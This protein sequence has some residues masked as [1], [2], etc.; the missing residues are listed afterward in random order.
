MFEQFQK[1]AN[2]YFL[3]IAILQS[4]PQISVTGGIPNILLPLSFVLFVSATKD[5]FEDIKRSKSDKEENMR[6]T[7]KRV[8]GE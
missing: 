7:L 8:E 4:V 3:I 5:L 2:V 6:M 1:S